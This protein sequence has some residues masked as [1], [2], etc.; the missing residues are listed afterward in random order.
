MIY[1]PPGKNNHQGEYNRLKERAFRLK[2]MRFINAVP[3]KDMRSI[4]A[5]AKFLVNTSDFEGFPNTFIEAALENTPVIS[6]KV[7]PNKMFSCHGA[8]ICTDS[9][10]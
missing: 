3:H 7:D 10:G 8:G 4:F 9:I 2:N 1:N 6:M 5:E